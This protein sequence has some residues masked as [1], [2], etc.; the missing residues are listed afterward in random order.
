MERE[1]W[2]GVVAAVRAAAVGHR[3]RQR[4]FFDQI[5][6]LTLL[7]AVLHDRPILWATDPR[8]WPFYMRIK[9]R[10]TASTMSR[11]LRSASVLALLERVR[12]HLASTP[13]AGVVLIIDAKPLPVGGYTT[14]KDARTGRACGCYAWGYKLYLVIDENG[15]LHAWKVE[16]M[17]VAEQVVAEEIIPAASRSAGKDRWI[18]GDRVYDS[19]RLHNVAEACGLRL[20]TPRMRIKDRVGPVQSPGRLRAIQMLEAPGT[21]EGQT[22]MARR[23]TIERY[24]GTFCCSG[25]GLSPLPGYVRGLRRA[26]LWVGA[27]L[28]IHSVRLALPRSVAA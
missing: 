22:L 20:L 17:N 16:S 2:T 12:D 9:S 27:K 8:N 18:L 28:L 6:V 26:R 13:Q 7:W 11:R 10:P 23:E 4:K 3:Q 25:G 14:D 1:L 15:G 19:N 24:L 21:P 5:I